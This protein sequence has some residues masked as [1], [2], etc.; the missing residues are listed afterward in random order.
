M[1]TRPD[2]WGSRTVTRSRGDRTS[3]IVVVPQAL[4]VL[5]ASVL[6]AAAI[7]GV[8]GTLAFVQ[9]PSGVRGPA[10]AAAGLNPMDLAARAGC[11]SGCL[12]RA[13]VMHELDTLP[14]VLDAELLAD[15]TRAEPEAPMAATPPPATVRLKTGGDKGEDDDG[16]DEGT[17]ARAGKKDGKADD[18]ESSGK[19]PGNGRGEGDD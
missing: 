13:G 19:G 8:V 5:R 17:G 16:H 3:E 7:I 11:G 14:V 2:L 10:E 1:S 12:G 15:V 6:G 9:V 18:G 4:Y